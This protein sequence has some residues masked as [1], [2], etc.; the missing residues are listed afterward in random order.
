M[1][2]H[3]NLNYRFFMIISYAIL[4][5]LGC[6]IALPTHSQSTNYLIDRVCETGAEQASED[7]EKLE[8]GLK[9]ILSNTKPGTPE[10]DSQINEYNEWFERRYD[11]Y[12]E[13]K[14]KAVANF[15][16]SA[17]YGSLSS[18]DREHEEAEI[19][20]YYLVLSAAMTAAKVII[21]NRVVRMEPSISTARYRRLI[22]GEC[23]AVFR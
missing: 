19:S 14:R 4:L 7:A 17:Q 5:F 23:R 9:K 20:F 18:I 16:A 1:A 6:S 12:A 15:R 13:A 21:S 10:R 22:E 3:L 11:F 8:Q 2:S